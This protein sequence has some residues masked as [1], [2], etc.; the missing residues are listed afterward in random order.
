MQK[1]IRKEVRR[2]TT[3]KINGT[4]R[5]TVMKEIRDKKL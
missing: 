4:H 3:K 5:K 1:A 2:F